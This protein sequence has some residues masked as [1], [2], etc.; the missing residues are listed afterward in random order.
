M[1]FILNMAKNFMYLNFHF[2]KGQL[3]DV[4]PGQ[5]KRVVFV[6]KKSK[7]MT[8]LYKQWCAASEQE[9]GV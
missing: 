1:R 5:N 3:V 9:K 7:E 2:S 4:I 8:E 6:W